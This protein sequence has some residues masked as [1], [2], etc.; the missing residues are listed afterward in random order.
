MVNPAM[1]LFTSRASSTLN[2]TKMPQ[3]K[4][5]SDFATIRSYYAWSKEHGILPPPDYSKNE[6]P[7]GKW[8]ADRGYG[9]GMA[10]AFQ[11]N[12]EFIRRS[13]NFAVNFLLSD[14]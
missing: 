14:K 8:I 1:K 9:T 10:L 3:E 2:P 4:D 6:P 13:V 11:G 12:P 7:V 5:N